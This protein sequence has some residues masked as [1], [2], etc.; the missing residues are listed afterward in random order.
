MGVIHVIQSCLCIDLH[1]ILLLG[2]EEG[3]G[4]WG[5]AKGPMGLCRM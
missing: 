4:G 2:A 1:N 3:G 5:G